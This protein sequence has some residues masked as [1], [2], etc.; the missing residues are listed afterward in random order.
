MLVGG[1]TAIVGVVVL[2]ARERS[3]AADPSSAVTTSAAAGAS[4]PTMAPPEVAIPNAGA[5]GD[6][7]APRTRP[8][9]PRPIPG[10]KAPASGSTP[11]PAPGSRCVPPFFF[12][13]QGNRIFKKECL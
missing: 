10:G 5:E 11:L 4:P 12:D 8:S 1:A 9:N 7:A 13:A 2:V 3:P 6:A